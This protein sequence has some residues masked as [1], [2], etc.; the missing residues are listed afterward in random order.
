MSIW[1][2]IK[3]SLSRSHIVEYFFNHSFI[4]TEIKIIH[5]LPR[6]STLVQWVTKFYRLVN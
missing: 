1:G 4:S 6:V 3:A 2:N 5:Q